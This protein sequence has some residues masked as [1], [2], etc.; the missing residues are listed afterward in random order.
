MFEGLW[1]LRRDRW[2][3]MDILNEVFG[4]WVT[5]LSPL[6][7]TLVAHWEKNRIKPFAGSMDDLFEQRVHHVHFSFPKK[8]WSFPRKRSDAIEVLKE[9]A[10]EAHPDLFK[11]FGMWWDI[12]DEVCG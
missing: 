4:P 8:P 6:Y 2:Y 5:L 7:S 12:R 1:D 10:P 3:D 11:I 9:M